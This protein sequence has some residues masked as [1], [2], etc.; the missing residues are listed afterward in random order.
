MN[1][2]TRPPSEYDR[3]GNSWV[4]IAAEIVHGRI[5]IDGRMSDSPISMLTRTDQGSWMATARSVDAEHL[6][7]HTKHLIKEEIP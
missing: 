5:M 7:R 4:N 1:L 2:H 6:I 3:F